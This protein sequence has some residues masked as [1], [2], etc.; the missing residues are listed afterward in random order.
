MGAWSLNFIPNVSLTPQ[1]HF[2]NLINDANQ[3]I[4]IVE[5]SLVSISSIF[6]GIIAILES[7]YKPGYRLFQ[8]LQ[9]SK[10]FGEIDVWGFAL[11]SKAIEWVTVRDL[12]FNLVYDGWISAFSDDGDNSGELLLRDVEVYRNTTE[13]FLYKIPALYISR[14]KTKISLEFRGVQF[15]AS[16]EESN[17]EK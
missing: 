13:D 11:N 6:L 16:S 4:N 5:V 14:E 8:K 2:Q 7:T 9:I 3:D 10:K 12:E 15:S 17:K 1:F